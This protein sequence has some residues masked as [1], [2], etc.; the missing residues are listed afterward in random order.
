MPIHWSNEEVWNANHIDSCWWLLL[1][2]FFFF[3][4]FLFSPC[5]LPIFDLTHVQVKSGIKRLQTF[6]RHSFFKLSS[7][8]ISS[9]KSGTRWIS[10]LFTF[11]YSQNKLV[12]I[13][14]RRDDINK[15]SGVYS[16]LYSDLN[17]DSFSEWDG[18]F[19]KKARGNVNPTCSHKLC[20]SHNALRNI[21][22]YTKGA[23][24]MHHPFQAI[25]DAQIKF[26]PIF[27][28]I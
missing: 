3:F 15:S 5:F 27:S 26:V 10:D 13:T 11:N 9:Q 16:F 20:C 28:I 8:F 1:L 21:S 22:I 25:T 6:S 23:I 18:T 12:P 17:A 24:F 14:K 2:F 7:Y 4:S 19:I